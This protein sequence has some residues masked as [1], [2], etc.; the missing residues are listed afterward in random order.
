MIGGVSLILELT[1]KCSRRRNCAFVLQTISSCKPFSCAGSGPNSVSCARSRGR[2]SLQ[3]VVR[4]HLCFS[5]LAPA[6][7]PISRA[8]SLALTC[9][10]ELSVEETLCLEPLKGM[11]CK[12]PQVS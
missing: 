10:G 6:L 11:V 2:N 9:T 5:P 7:S 1:T 8:S 12:S 3:D 4:R